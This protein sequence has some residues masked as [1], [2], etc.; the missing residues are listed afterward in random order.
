MNVVISTQALR[1]LVRHDVLGW[2]PVDEVQARALPVVRRRQ[3]GG[4]SR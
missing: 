4:R 2:E 1:L 3:G